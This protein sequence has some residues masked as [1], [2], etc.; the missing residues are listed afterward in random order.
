MKHEPDGKLSTRSSGFTSIQQLPTKSRS[1]KEYKELYSKTPVR[2][3]NM[4]MCNLSLTNQMDQ[5]IKL[6][7][8]YANNVTNRKELIEQ[9]IQGNPFDINYELSN[10]ESNTSKII[11]ALLKCL[12]LEIVN[13]KTK[14]EKNK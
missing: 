11:K 6:L 3:G 14:K 8:S 13:I 9:S 5:V 7:N 10:T 2:I 4:E 1:F 12:S